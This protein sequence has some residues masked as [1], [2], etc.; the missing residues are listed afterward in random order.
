MTQERKD[1]LYKEVCKDILLK[2]VSTGA[3]LPDKYD[4]NT[5]A[6]DEYNRKYRLHTINAYLQRAKSSNDLAAT[7]IANHE[8][9][10]YRLADALAPKENFYLST[11]E[12]VLNDF[13]ETLSKYH[14]EAK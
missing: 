5:L 9:E 3:P 6:Q 1:I 12:E 11:G 2:R 8:E 7:L 4:L 14:V 13:K 10:A